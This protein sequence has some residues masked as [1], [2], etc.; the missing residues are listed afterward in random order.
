MNAN[1]TTRGKNYLGA[2]LGNHKFCRD[3]LQAKIKEWA[4][5]IEKL[6]SFAQSQPHGV[7]EC[8]YTWYC[9]KMDLYG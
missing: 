9:W 3:F 7:G 4:I 5:L 1:I 8:I 6:S 2:P